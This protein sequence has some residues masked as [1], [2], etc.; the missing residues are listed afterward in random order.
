HM[1][2]Q[3]ISRVTLAETLGKSKSYVSQVLSGNRNMT[4]A[5]LADVAYALRLQIKMQLTDA[6]QTDDTWEDFALPKNKSSNIV[7][8][9]NQHQVGQ[10]CTYEEGGMIVDR[11]TQQVAA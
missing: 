7:A 11:Y 8:I 1:E 5:T 9:G 4:L 6:R 3:R 10:S 2:E